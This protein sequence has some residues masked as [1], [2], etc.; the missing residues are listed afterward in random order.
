MEKQTNKTEQLKAPNAYNEYLFAL[1]AGL[2][3]EIL[4]VQAEVNLLQKFSDNLPLIATAT[5]G[6]L[7]IWAFSGLYIIDYLW[8]NS[9][10]KLGI[11]DEKV[12]FKIK[13]SYTFGIALGLALTLPQIL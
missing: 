6:V 5:I 7:G 8:M 11:Q 13:S 12:L 1:L 2:A 3:S 9:I 10:S 4:L